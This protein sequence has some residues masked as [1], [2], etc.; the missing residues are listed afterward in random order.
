MKGNNKEW[1]DGY[2]NENVIILEDLDLGGRAM[3]HQIKHWADQY[4][5]RAEIKG[6]HIWLRHKWFIVTSNYGPDEVFGP[7]KDK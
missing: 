1:F 7:D 6:G 3:G 4:A 5:C 2:E